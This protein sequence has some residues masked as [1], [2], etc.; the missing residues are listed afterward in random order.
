MR[1]S[2]I[3]VLMA[4]AVL[5][6]A[7]FPQ[8]RKANRAAVASA[9]GRPA[10]LW[11]NPTDIQSRNLFYGPGGKEHEPHGTFTFVKEDLAGTNP[12][13]VVEDRDGVKWKVKLGAEARP[14]T[15]A[16]RLVWAAGYSASEDYFV[17]RLP[18]RGL[19]ARLHRG[20]K[21]VT[22]DG[23]VADVRLKREPK[24]EHK[25]GTWPWRQSPFLA[26]RELNG[27][28]VLM[29]VIN[30]WDLKD[31]NNAIYQ[32]GPERLYLVSDLGASFGT[33]GETR[34]RE[35]A[36]GNLDSYIHSRFIHKVRP[37]TVDFCVP[38]RP[39]YKILVNPR[40]YL[41]R[42]RLEWIG[43]DIPRD[44]ARWMGRLLARLSPQQIRDAFRAAEYSPP[45]VEAFAKALESR[46]A[47]LLEL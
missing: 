2:T 3:A 44:D 42:V 7:A 16:S 14:E 23:S 41:R 6:P 15:V 21:L 19:P 1:G 18:V 43:K 32:E 26:T 31:E 47:A 38:A 13:F 46:I 45:E 20:W 28:K 10:V 27:L 22:S 12:K 29:A 40:E 17:P 8:A 9:P 11:R 30:N 39:N 36:R 24:G 25:I 5:S 34:P 37:N 4:A 35:K 33:A